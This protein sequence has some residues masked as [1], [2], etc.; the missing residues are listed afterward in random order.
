MK[1]AG[2]IQKMG[3]FIVDGIGAGSGK[4]QIWEKHGWH[5]FLASVLER[6]RQVVYLGNSHFCLDALVLHVA[7]FAKPLTGC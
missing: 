3:L 6:L 1:N 2:H 5:F 4:R 7:V